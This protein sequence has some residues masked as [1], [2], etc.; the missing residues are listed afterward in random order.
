[1]RINKDGYFFEGGHNLNDEDDDE[2]LLE[3]IARQIEEKRAKRN[4]VSRDLALECDLAH[5]ESPWL[6]GS[7][8]EV[9]HSFIDFLAKADDVEACVARMRILAERLIEEADRLAAKGA[10]NF[11][12]SFDLH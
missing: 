8:I 2:S 7:T 6:C 11:H 12:Q 9:L 10:E 3:R 1:M 4:D 5:I